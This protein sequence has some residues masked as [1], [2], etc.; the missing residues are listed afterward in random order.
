MKTLFYFLL[1][2]SLCSQQKP[3]V[4]FITIDDMN[5]DITLFGKDRPYKTPAIE[6]LAKR[7]VFF[8]RAYCASPACNPSRA[9]TL[10]GLRTHKTG[11]Y[12]NK[13]DW[14]KAIGDHLT[15]PEYFGKHGYKTAGFGKVYH[16]HYDGAF[17]DP[18]AWDQF[19]KMDQQYMPPK[20]LYGDIKYGSKNSDWGAWPIDDDEE[21]TI[22]FKSVSY[23][24]D[25]LNQ[26]HEKPFFLACGIFKPHSPFYAPP[27][28]HAMYDETLQMP[29]L[30]DK[31]W[32]DLPSGAVQLM[33]KKKW[34]WNGMM[35]I[36]KAIPGSYQN[37][38]KSYAACST[39]AD[40]SI[41]RLLDG[42]KQ[43]GHEDNT[44]I[45]LWSDHGFHL[46]EK[47]HIEKFALWEKANHIPFII[48]DPR[49]KSSAGKICGQPIDMTTIFPTLIELCGLP[50]YE[51][52]DG[53]SS[54]EL[55][56]APDKKWNMPALMTYDFNNHALRTERWRYIR[57]ADGTEEL[58]DHESDPHEWTNIAEKED[59]SALLE[60]FRKQ[61]PKENKEAFKDLKKPNG[62]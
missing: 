58:Y 14:R 7:G 39:F 59:H 11:I 5:D 17:N 25:F 26:K 34:F 21:K 20:K 8:N 53:K 45:I 42:L 23:S 56:N 13:T 19:K 60:N 47:D 48:V 62:H 22:D 41:K 36:D 49:K 2:L 46:G 1:T 35:K 37:F 55:V 50:K 27:K 52:L 40:A 57:Y 16:H 51:K 3:N 24:L 6:S 12:G 4:L 38:I 33:K 18:K 15:L 31:D 30:N 32:S 43:S 61:I 28:Y 44:I 9:S 10:S 29:F 54:A